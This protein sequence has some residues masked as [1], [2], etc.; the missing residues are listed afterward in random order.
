[1]IVSGP[2][3]RGQYTMY[4]SVVMRIPPNVRVELTDPKLEF[5]L[6]DNTQPHKLTFRIRGKG[7]LVREPD[8]RPF[9]RSI[10]LDAEL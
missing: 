4:F 7:D 6:L 10:E 3:E 1:M 5:E 8:L 2:N 9:I